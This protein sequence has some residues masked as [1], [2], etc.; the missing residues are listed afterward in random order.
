MHLCRV[1][2]FIIILASFTQRVTFSSFSYHHNPCHCHL[3]L[4]QT[5]HQ[6][7]SHSFT[8]LAFVV[9]TH[10]PTRTSRCR[11]PFLSI[12][13]LLSG[14]I[15]LNPG[16]TNFT[17]CTINIRSVLHPL[18]SAAL[19]D[20]IDLH[21][22]DLFCLT[23]TWIKSTTTATELAHCTP[24]NYTFLSFPRNV[25]KNV[26]CTVTGG[27]TGFFIK[28]PFTQLPSVLPN[29]S[30]FES[31]SV[32]LKLPHSKI[33]FFN[34]YRPPS[35]SQF[36]KPFSV[37][38]DEF[39]SFLS[40][41]ATTP[42][43]FLITGDFNL[44]VDNPA[45]NQ[46]SQF[47][48]VLSSFNLTQ[49]V[50]F[51]THIKNH[52]LDLV[53]SSADSSLTPS[54]STTHCSPSDH[55]PILTRLS[56]SPTPLPPPTLHSFRRVHSIDTDSFVS[57]LQSS[58]L[59]TNPP[60]SLGSL[61]ELYN[62]TLSSLLDKHAPVITRLSKHTSKSNPWFTST[63]RVFRSTVRRAE[64]IW[65]NTHSALDWSTFKHLRNR[66]HN[67]ILTAKKKYYSNLISSSTDNPRRLWQTVNYLLHRKSSSPL[68]S[69]SSA[70]SLA[71]SFA[72]FFTDKVSKLHLSLTSSSATT[73]PHSPSPSTSPP[74]FSTFQPASEAEISKILLGCPNKQSDS[75]PIPTCLLK[76]CASIL[77]PTITNIVNLSLN[78]GEFHPALKQSV[79][80][81]LL[82]K[83]TLD[84]DQLSNYRPI[85]NLS[86]LSKIIERVVKSRLTHHLSSNNLFN[87]NQSA[88]CKHHSTET[89]LLYIHDYLINAIGSQKISCLC[90]LDLSAAFDTIDHSIL[91]TR[92]SSWFG[93]HGSVLNWFKS[94]LSSRSFRV[95]CDNHMSSPHTCSCGV[96]QGSVL[97]PLLFIMYTTPLST[98]ISSLSLNHHLYADD[99]QLFFSFYPSE[100]DANITLLR[101]ALQHISSWMTANLLTLNTSKTE[102]LL[103]GLKQQLAKFQNCPIETTHSARN[104]G[105]IFDEHLTFSDQIS[106]LSKSCYSHIRALRCIRPYLDFRTAST[107]ATSIVH[108]KLD[109]CNSLYVNLPNSQINRLQQIQ[110][111]LART[112]V[113]SPKFSH[114]TP[115]IKSL[116]WLKIK[117]RIEYKLLS[118]TY[119]VLTTSQPTYLSKL[120]T[121]QSPRS[122]R[123][124]SV[125]TISR[126]PTSSSLKIT[127]RSFQHTAPRLWNKL[128]HS[129]RE[130]HPQSGLSPSHNSTQ[131]GSTLSSPPLSPSITPSLFHSRL[132]TH[133]FLKS[134]PP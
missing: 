22:P 119:K 9:G 86:L 12:L 68:P 122:T 55:F 121:V 5:A 6:E 79:I 49:H 98:L 69:F 28:E 88:Y 53:I 76:Q 107:I 87:P 18:H 58:P 54:L 125:V 11:D 72:S 92:L 37:F 133:L 33:S 134:F 124:S 29:Y 50:D 75:D 94:Y 10:S 65:K 96:P 56:V 16:P 93:I 106:S 128:P 1:L 101:N 116:H 48:S 112:V 111:S 110:N 83:A 115:V 63:L 108:S 70:T 99:T 130:P 129:F 100:L 41:A 89:A 4:H 38:L 97:G 104:L 24:P 71:N 109:Y 77:V 132:K 59:I 60:T 17:V 25:A 84:K 42:H 85:S 19:C 23:E 45:D 31:S 73:S 78:S 66:Y 30:S 13:L 61:I 27:G 44:H 34:I 131:I 103:I 52:T 57:D 8:P 91:I 105:I 14:D 20:L 7:H 102:F 36:S 117:E 35:S 26:S 47:L 32:T 40:V 43:E 82:K 81:P 74:D 2:I 67:L 64:S 118:L 3:T 127:N 113:K 95:K 46:I 80:S 62:D 123:S 120:V 21:H 39:N 126:P 114:I 90:L 51:P 15:E